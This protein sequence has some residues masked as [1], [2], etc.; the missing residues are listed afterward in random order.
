MPMLDSDRK[1]RG[2]IFLRH[3]NTQANTDRVSC[4]GDCGS[5]MDD[6]G[7]RQIRRAANSLRTRRIVPNLI[8][9]SKLQRTSESA[10]IIRTELNPGAEILFDTDISERFLG[11][12]NGQSQSITNPLLAA[13]KT[14][15][16][17][18]SR[19]EFKSRMMVFFN[20][21]LDRFF[22]WPLIVGSRGNARIL[23][24]LTQDPDAA[25]FPN[26][27]LLEV[28]LSQS[29]GFEVTHIKRIGTLED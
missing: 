14:P 22:D 13:G 9:S 26:G 23:L 21:H 16:G 28:H 6:L 20:R 18:E 8:F 1:V 24:E 19:A 10:E 27:K 29:E 4:G 2:F 7:R 25:N 15:K 5:Q 3:G 11:E 17:G 12:W